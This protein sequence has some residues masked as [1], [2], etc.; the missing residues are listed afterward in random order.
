MHFRT[1]YA[2]SDTFLSTLVF[3]IKNVRYGLTVQFL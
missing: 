2:P 3:N 1:A